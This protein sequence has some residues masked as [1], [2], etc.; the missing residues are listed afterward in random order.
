[1]NEQKLIEEERAQI[2]RREQMAR[3]EAEVSLRRFEF[4]AEASNL[5][6][7]SLDIPGIAKGLADRLRHIREDVEHFFELADGIALLP[8]VEQA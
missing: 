5:L 7:R 1:M 4:L 3:A 8:K 2:L 6:A